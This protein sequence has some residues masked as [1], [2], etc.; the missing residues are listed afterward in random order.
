MPNSGTGIGI[1]LNKKIEIKIDKKGLRQ[2]HVSTKTVVERLND[3]GFSA[4]EKSDSIALNASEMNFKEIYKL[5]EKLK[6]TII[7]GVKDVKQILIVK[8]ERDF[9]IITL[10][11]NLK[12]I[13]KMKEVNK[14]KLLSNDLYEVAGV[15]GIEASRQLIIN[16]INLFFSSIFFIILLHFF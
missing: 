14:D 16:E 3:L 1:I 4:K 10:G 7:S 9:V 5:K 12:D 2:T 8:K 11:T 6:K 15:F 13:I